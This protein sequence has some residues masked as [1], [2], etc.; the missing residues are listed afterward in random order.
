MKAIIFGILLFFF[1]TGLFLT[2]FF[3]HKARTKER[4]LLI[5]KGVDISNLSMGPS[6][7]LWLKIGIL[8]FSTALGL[9]LGALLRYQTNITAFQTGDTSLC[10]MI[11]F[12][13]IGMIVGHFVE[14]ANRLK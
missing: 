6:P 1:L 14:K 13:G 8:L 12:A 4:L 3:S 10:T 9:L 2:W 5:E 7:F 11:L